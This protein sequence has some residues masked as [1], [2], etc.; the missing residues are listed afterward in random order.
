MSEFVRLNTDLQKPETLF[1]TRHPG[2]LH[3]ILV[4][5][6]PYTGGVGMFQIKGG[7][8]MF[9]K[10]LSLL[11]CLALMAG[12]LSVYAASGSFT[13]EGEGF[14]SETP[15]KVTV[16]LK[17]GKIVALKIDEHAESVDQIPAVKEALDLIPAL[18]IE[19]NSAEVDVHAGATYTSKG[20]MAAV[21]AALE[22][23]SPSAE[24]AADAPAA[25]NASGSFTA[26]AEG[27]SSETK[28]KVTVTLKD[29]KI[30]A[31]KVDEHAESVDQIPAVKEALNAVPALIVEKNSAE[32]D[33]HAGATYTSKGIMAAV[34]AALEEAAKTATPAEAPAEQ[35]AETPAEAPAVPASDVSGSF[36]GEASGFHA[37]TPIKVTLTLDKGKITAVVVD[38]H[39]ESAGIADPA[40][41]A[42]PAR[43]VEKNS[44]DVDVVAGAT[45]TSKGIM[46]A[47]KAAL[48]AAG[49]VLDAPETPAADTPAEE[50]APAGPSGSFTAEAEGFSSETKI[51][52]TLTLK[53]GKIV[54]LKID[55][56]AESVDQ[57]PAVKE[58]LDAV[59]AAIVAKNS[60]EVD[61]HAGATYTS[62]GI[63]AAVLA[64]LEEAAKEPEQPAE[65]PAEAPAETPA[66]TPAASG[67]FTGEG[68]G[69]HSETKIKVTVTLEQGKITAVVI[70]N[71][72]ESAGISDPALEAIPAKIVEANSADVDVVAGA[73]WTSKGIMAAVKAALAAAGGEAP[74]DEASAE[75]VVIEAAGVTLGLGVHNSGRIGPGKDDKEVQVYSI[76]QV[77]AGVLFDAEGKI[78]YA[79]LDQLEVATPNYDGAGMPHFAGFPGQLPYL[80]DSDHDGKI[81][82]VLETNDEDFQKDIAAWQTKRERGS[83]YKM[84]L[85]TWEDQ[86]NAYEAFFVGKT[87][88][89][90]EGLFARVFS[91]RNGRPLKDGST[92]EEDKAKY[93]ALSDEDKALLAEVTTGA[94]MSLNDSHGNLLAALKAAYE[95]RRPVADSAAAIGLGVDFSGRIGPGK[96]NTETQVYSINQVIALT[97]F[98]GED[99][100]VQSFVDQIEVATPNYDGAGMPHFSGFPGQGGYNY[101]AD[102]DEKVDGKL[103]TNNEGFQAEIAGWQTKRDRGSSYKMN[104]ATWADEMDAY[105]AFFAGKTLDELDELFARVFSSR[106]G[107]PLKDGSTNEE[108]KA[109]YDALSDEDKALLADVTSGATMSLNDSHGNILGALRDSLTKKQPVALTVAK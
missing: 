18:I 1:C 37:E 108:D 16:T 92:N 19:K 9:K 79:K 26:E 30:V 43:I 29:G 106:N 3:L 61:V 27:F 23:A 8:F 17:D 53:D 35:P 34:K 58:A 71:H 89:E 85:G 101:D 48:T 60:A 68:E 99:K 2:S 50:A 95:N 93:D 94:T 51:K 57:I 52:V 5:A 81:D 44:P 64:A 87:V 104:L 65:Q 69:F 102:H 86:M 6:F 4:R 98:D 66:E 103:I 41:E 78:L 82:G 40:L 31:L 105:E 12:A 38:S 91:D 10:T 62:K 107:R 109:K 46:A 75:P 74:A 83:S 33:V 7:Y 55:E 100:I 96:D 15:I 14:S 24:P 32:V 11:L 73:T 54:A 49:V 84:N 28:I 21:K 97:L 42:I 72:E 88:E 90:L 77:F 47:V 20:I 39:E 76:N 63:M 56:H 25:N 13:A 59:P 70:D 67:S 80:Y 22:Q 36:T 45:W